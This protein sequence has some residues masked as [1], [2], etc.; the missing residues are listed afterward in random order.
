M[1]YWF[2][3]YFLCHLPEPLSFYATLEH[4]SFWGWFG[5]RVVPPWFGGFDY[6]RFGGL[7]GCQIPGVGEV[8]Q[9]R[10][11]FDYYRLIFLQNEG[12]LDPHGKSLIFSI[13][14]NTSWNIWNRGADNYQTHRHKC[15][16]IR[17]L[18]FVC[19][20]IWIISNFFI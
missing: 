3:T 13:D 10:K 14:M 20:I 19:C 4:Q 17:M 9:M 16:A 15:P 6:F 7:G 18:S 12:L 8:P 11:K 5:G 2:F 1:E